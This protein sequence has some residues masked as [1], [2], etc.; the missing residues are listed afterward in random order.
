M[1]LLRQCLL[2]L[3][4]RQAE[5]SEADSRRLHSVF[6]AMP[7]RTRSLMLPQHKVLG[8]SGRKVQDDHRRR[9]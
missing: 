5:A 2:E 1:A 8:E 6:G 7:S 9:P 3:R 4:A